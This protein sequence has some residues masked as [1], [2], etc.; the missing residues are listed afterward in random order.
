[1]W[2]AVCPLLVLAKMGTTFQPYGVLSLLGVFLVLLFPFKPARPELVTSGRFA[3][4]LSLA[5][6]L[7]VAAFFAE[8][9]TTHVPGIDNKRGVT[10][11]FEVMRRHATDAGRKR[12]RLGLVHWG[13]LHDASLVDSLIFDMGAR[14]ATPSYEPS[15]RAQ[16][17]SF[18][19]EPI[20]LDPWAWEP[21]VTVKD[22]VSPEEWTKRL[23]EDADYVLVLGGSRNQD[24]RKGRWPR[25]LEASER[26]QASGVFEPLGSPFWIPRDGR[27]ELWVRKKRGRR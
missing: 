20:T 17:T 3:A 6:A 1:L 26:I 13:A 10:T 21:A 2:L 25:W 18:I 22:I 16:A 9:R 19:V 23:I 5:C 11:A 27:V 15:K 8:L 24:R 4:V 7:S 12:V 14:V